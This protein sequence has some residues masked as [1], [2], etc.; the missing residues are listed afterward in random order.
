[1][2]FSRREYWSGLPFSTPG[3]LPNPGI[4]PAS[5]KSPA[6][7][8][9]SFTTVSWGKH[10][11]VIVYLLS[12]KGRSSVFHLCDLGTLQLFNVHSKKN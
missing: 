9:G 11:T 12:L 8:A 7:Q 4:E 2:A 10:D 1:M 6:W 3:D 5:L